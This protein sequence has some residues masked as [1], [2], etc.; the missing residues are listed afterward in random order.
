MKA[1]A[2]SDVNDIMFDSEKPEE[3]IYDP[4][5]NLKFTDGLNT[6]N[7]FDIVEHTIRHW[8]DGDVTTTTLN[9]EHK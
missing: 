8:H 2:M 6:K 3:Y 4:E 9:V 1:A 5:Q 7:E